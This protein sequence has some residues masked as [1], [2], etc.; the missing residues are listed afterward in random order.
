MMKNLLICG[1]LFLAACTKSIDKQTVPVKE[2]ERQSC[3]FG[4]TQFNLSKRPAGYA[5]ESLAKGPKGGGNGGNGGG[6]GGGTTTSPNGGVIYLDFDGQTVT[7]TTWNSYIGGV[8]IVCA[9]ANMTATEISL[10]VQRIAND[11]SPFNITVTT[12]ESVYNAANIYKRTRVIVTESWEW[13]GQ[14]GGVAF[15]GTFTSGTN[16]PCFVFSSLLSYNSRY[17]GE[18]AAHEAGHTLGLRHQS[19]YD[20]NC[21]KTDEYNPGYGEG[22]IGW[23]PI[24]GVSYYQNLSLWHR[25]TSA[26]ACTNIQDDEAIISAAVGYSPDDYSNSTSGAAALSTSLNGVINTNTDVDYFSV[27]LSTTRTLSLTPFNVGSFN[28]GA[29]VDLIVKV[30]NNQGALITMLDNPAALNVSTVL[31]PGSYYV[32]V[33][34]IANPFSSTYGMIGKYNISLY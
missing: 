12:S 6:G 16:T 11:Y 7:G 19:S 28:A 23:A 21:V 33:G 17:V 5:D 8:D 22:E 9:P 3:D 20:I 25:G 4:I 34:N 26:A 14:A 15:L 13:Y 29:D 27:N 1:M 24:M 31:T 18:A 10:A 30:Y 2:N 32:S